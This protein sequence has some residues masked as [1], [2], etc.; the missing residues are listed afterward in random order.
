MVSPCIGKKAAY[1]N[2]MFDTKPYREKKKKTPAKEVKSKPTVAPSVY[3]PE[4]AWNSQDGM[5]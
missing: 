3:R 5:Q 1:K 2:M 4:N